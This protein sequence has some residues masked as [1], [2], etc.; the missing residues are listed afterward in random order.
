MSEGSTRPSPRASDGA[1][2]RVTILG[3]TGS[4]GCNTA[5]LVA[6]QPEAY[7]VEALVAHRNV[8]R[9]AQQARALGAKLAVVAEDSQYRELK[10]ALAGSGIEGRCGEARIG[11]RLQIQYRAPAVRRSEIRHDCTRNSFS[12]ARKRRNLGSS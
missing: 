9:L 10:A 8:E 2:R 3:S 1:P 12:T 4:V 11:P 6:A 7:A 5:E